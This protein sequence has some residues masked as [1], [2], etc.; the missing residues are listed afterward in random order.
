MS[1]SQSIQAGLNQLLQKMDTSDQQAAFAF[2]SKLFF[3]KN[4]LQLV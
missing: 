1:D 4:L 3:F 2:I